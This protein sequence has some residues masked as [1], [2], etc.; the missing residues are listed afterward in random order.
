MAA[1][2]R[3]L[4]IVG[5]GAHLDDCYLGMGGVAIKAARLGHRVALVQ[6]VSQ[7]GAWPTVSGRS[8]EIKLL[9]SELAARAGVF[10][11]AL[12][13]DY[14]RLE[15]GATLVSELSRVLHGLGPDLLFCQHTVDTNQDH[16]ALGQAT[17]TAA[18]H[19]AC[20]VGRDFV[21]PREIYRYTTG[22]QTLGFA[23]D[24]YV[25]ISEELPEVLEITAAVDRMYAGGGMRIEERLILSGSDLGGRTVNVTTHGM[26]KLASSILYGMRSGARYA[27]GFAAYPHRRA[28]ACLLDL[29]S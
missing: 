9:L 19:G 27:E 8:E 2:T 20:F 17:V 16:V 28:G 26:D 12:G 23:P 7:Y 25:D 13:H 4:S 21:V 14:M 6:A 3:R 11:V 5:I 22:A 18:L 15:N 24:T 1:E 10:V 29:L